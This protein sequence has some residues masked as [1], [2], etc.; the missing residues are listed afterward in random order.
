MSFLAGMGFSTMSCPPTDT[1]PAVGGMNPVIIRIVVDL[2]AP[3]GPRKPR[4]SPRST[5]NVTP[6]TARFVPKCFSKFSTLIMQLL[7][8]FRVEQAVEITLRPPACKGGTP[9]HLCNRGGRRTA[10]FRRFTCAA[11]D[12]S[13][14][15][16]NSQL[17]TN[18]RQ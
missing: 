18:P 5:E 2:P 17:A 4:I 1:L 15:G 3:L 10:H 8:F 14:D 9:L 13:F 6:A 16:N 11:A 12:G 7:Q